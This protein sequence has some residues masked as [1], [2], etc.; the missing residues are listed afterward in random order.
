MAAIPPFA[1]APALVGA[2]QPLDYSTQVGQHL[3]STAT[4][5]LPYTFNGKNHPHQHFLQATCDCAAQSGW[6]NI[7][8]ITTDAGPR[9]LLSQYGEISIENVRADAGLDY[10]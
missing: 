1:L 7:F 4:T 9:N 6:D 8:E 5:E 2:G 10:D 3:Y